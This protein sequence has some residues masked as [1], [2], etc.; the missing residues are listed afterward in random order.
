MSDLLLSYGIASYVSAD[1]LFVP[2]QADFYTEVMEALQQDLSQQI[3]N[4]SRIKG[5]ILDVSKVQLMD[6]HNMH[7]L[8]QLIELGNILGVPG[9][10]VGVQPNVA[11][12][13]IDLGYDPAHLNTVVNLERA[14][15]LIRDVR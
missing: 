13:L 1:I 4:N 7:T 9:F 11:L 2:F 8:E 15:S 12:T 14:V 5:L 10:L 3:H 6:L